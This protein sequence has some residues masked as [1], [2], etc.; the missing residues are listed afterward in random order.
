MFLNYTLFFAFLAT[1]LIPLCSGNVEID[2]A[3]I[4]NDDVGPLY[5]IYDLPEEYWWRWPKPGTDCSENGYVGHEH[6]INSGMGELLIPDDGL[7]LTWHFSLF[8]SLYNR[9]K[10]SKRRTRDPE[11]ASL[12][13]IPYDLGLDGY[14]IAWGNISI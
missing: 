3:F 1:F 9:M 7:F 10:R 12:F 5:Y 13:I 6:S 4:S 11:K 2:N 8:S 14:L